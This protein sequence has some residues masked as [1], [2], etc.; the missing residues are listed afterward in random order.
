MY[1]IPYNIQKLYHFQRMK[2]NIKR[3]PLEDNWKLHL[4]KENE[5]REARGSQFSRIAYANCT[6]AH[7]WYESD[8]MMYNVMHS[9]YNQH[10]R[11]Q[12]SL[13]HLWCTSHSN[14]IISFLNSVNWVCTFQ[15]ENS[16]LI[17]IYHFINLSKMRTRNNHKYDSIHGFASD[18][19]SIHIWYRILLALHISFS[20]TVR[21]RQLPNN[22]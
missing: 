1:D 22:S 4:S 10:C 7:N 14:E 19:A 17:N 21:G 16:V 20:I 6:V 18:S 8:G 2:L 13:Y 12:Q 9:D 11:T 3:Q 15:C 5:K